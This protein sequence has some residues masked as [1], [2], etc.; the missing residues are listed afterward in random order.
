[1]A[2]LVDIAPSVEHVTVGAA[3]VPVYGVSAKGIA[4]LLARFPELRELMSGREVGIDKLL[5]MGGDAVAAIIAAGCGFPGDEAQEAAAERLPVE[6]QADLL[7]P[8]LRLTMPNGVGPFVEKL[9]ALGN[10]LGAV[11]SSTEPGSKSPKRSTSSVVA[12]IRA[13]KSG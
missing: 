8:I 7:A 12:D 13:A 2:G 1:M 9:A 6:L 10:V 11:P 5:D 3:K 4:L